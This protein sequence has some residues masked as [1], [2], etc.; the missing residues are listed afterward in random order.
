MHRLE[1]GVRSWWRGLWPELVE[2]DTYRE[3]KRVDA[4]LKEWP[5]AIPLM[6]AGL[7]DLSAIGP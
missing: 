1:N 2:L 6:E 7:S 5:N 4:K 3:L